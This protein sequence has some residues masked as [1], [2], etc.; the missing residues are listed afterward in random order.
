MFYFNDAG[1]SKEYIITEIIL[2][3]DNDKLEQIAELL[4]DKLDDYKITENH[5]DV[6]FDFVLNHI[7]NGNIDL[8]LNFHCD[9]I[10]DISTSNEVD[11][12]NELFVE[13]ENKKYVSSSGI[14]YTDWDVVVLEEF[15]INKM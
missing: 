11:M 10:K 2:D 13:T 4:E 5:K 3:L 14:F 8:I 12:L 15:T 7:G 9:E 1:D 6:D